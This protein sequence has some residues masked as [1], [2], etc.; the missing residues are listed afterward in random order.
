[1]VLPAKSSLHNP[2]KHNF[3]WAVQEIGFYLL[4]RPW[5]YLLECVKIIH[6]NC[7][8]QVSRIENRGGSYRC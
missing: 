1:M 7:Q 2:P 6:V 3:R 4:L 5:I 8:L